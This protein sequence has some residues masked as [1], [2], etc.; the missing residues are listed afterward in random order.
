MLLSS[1]DKAIGSVEG[2]TVDT[3]ARLTSEGSSA[4]RLDGRSGLSAQT[5]RWAGRGPWPVARGQGGGQWPQGPRARGRA[6]AECW[7]SFTVL[8]RER[9]G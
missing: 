5:L 4:C 3:T 1:I 2:W 8:A 9:Q 6:G 7:G